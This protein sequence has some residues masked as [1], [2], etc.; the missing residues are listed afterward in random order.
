MTIAVAD[1]LTLLFF[2][3]KM[4]LA[5][6]MENCNMITERLTVS[7]RGYITLPLSIRKEMDI[8]S[9][10]NILISREENKI[11]LQPVSSFTEKLTGLTAGSFGK[12]T[13]QIQEYMDKEREDR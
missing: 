10:T 2:A 3:A 13:E 12:T 9:G 5:S 4:N 8:K 7:N 11:I 6:L 1:M